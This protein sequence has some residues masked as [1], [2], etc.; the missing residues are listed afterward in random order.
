[1]TALEV[2]KNDERVKAVIT[3]D[4]WVFARAK[5]MLDK[6]YVLDKP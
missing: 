6:E 3:L 4:P 1:M 5:E 2:A